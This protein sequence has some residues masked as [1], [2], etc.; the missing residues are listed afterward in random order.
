MCKC[1]V[2]VLIKEIQE[3][4]PHFSCDQHLLAE[5]YPPPQM[6]LQLALHDLVN[7]EVILQKQ[8]YDTRRSLHLD[9]CAKE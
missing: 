8:L 6:L 3:I 4:D 1:R 9:V 2:I 5:D 7:L